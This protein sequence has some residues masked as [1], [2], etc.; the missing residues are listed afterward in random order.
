MQTSGA[1]CRENTDSRLKLFWPFENRIGGN[2]L[3]TGAPRPQLSS[4]ATGARR[5]RDAVA[6]DDGSLWS[7]HACLSVS[8]PP[9]RRKPR[10]RRK[11][12]LAGIAAHNGLAL[13]IA[14]HVLD[15][16]EAVGRQL[17]DRVDDVFRG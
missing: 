17:L 9:H 11:A 4:P 2:A 3:R 13:R 12:G 1:T 7:S 5:R 15:I 8:L 14:Q 10:H 16:I 6:G